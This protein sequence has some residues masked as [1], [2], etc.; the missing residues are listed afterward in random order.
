MSERL[1]ITR[2]E[3]R[4]IAAVA[5]E[6]NCVFEIEHDGVI[7]RV[8]PEELAR[9]ALRESASNNRRPLGL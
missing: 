7:Y 4:D 3:A 9:E 2:R 1:A 6:K 8:I 5:A